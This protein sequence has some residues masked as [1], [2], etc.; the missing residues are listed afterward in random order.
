MVIFFLIHELAEQTVQHSEG[1]LWFISVL[2]IA[3]QGSKGR[4]IGEGKRRATMQ[5]FFGVNAGAMILC[6]LKATRLI[7]SKCHQILAVTATKN[8]VGF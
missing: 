8:N 3:R 1:L 4:I 5:N 7:F 2:R 6:P